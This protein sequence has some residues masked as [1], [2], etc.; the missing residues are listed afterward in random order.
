ME[1]INI[2]NILYE[3]ETFVLSCVN[4][5]DQHL[6]LVFLIYECS[7]LEAVY[8]LCVILCVPYYQ[9]IIL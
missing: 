4:I 1:N 7:P 5:N 3:A 8:I 2:L 6:F 9:V